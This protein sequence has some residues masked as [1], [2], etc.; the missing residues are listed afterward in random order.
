MILDRLPVGMFQC[1]CYLI[2]DPETKRGML[3]DPGDEA[4]AILRMVRKHDVTV[5]DIVLTHAHLDHVCGVQMIRRETGATVHLNEKDLPLYQ[6]VQKQG[7]MFGLEV[8]Q[9]DAPDRYLIHDQVIGSGGLT[10]RVIET[11][12]HSPGSVSL[13][14]ESGNGL[15]FTGDTLFAGSI[16]R[17][18]LWGGSYDQIIE[19]IK[20]RLLT[21]E[22]DVPVHPGHGDLTSI[23]EE[24]RFNPFL[25]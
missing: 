24:R 1:N 12:G 22:H 25:T 4:E 23:G 5:T 15:L 10:L 11:P 19:S 13:L 8:E 9:P 7:R 18:D 20:T 2:G 16:G 17:T 6:H 21:F 14:I 3:I